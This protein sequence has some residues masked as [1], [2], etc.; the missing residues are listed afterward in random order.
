M[1]GG[2]EKKEEKKEREKDKREI[3]NYDNEDNK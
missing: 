1:N 3:K 2:D